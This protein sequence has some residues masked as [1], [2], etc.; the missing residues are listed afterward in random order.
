MA[1]L[2]INS[3]A[4]PRIYTINDRKEFLKQINLLYEYDERAGI[5]EYDGGYCRE[6]AETLALMN[7]LTEHGYELECGFK[8]ITAARN[9]TKLKKHNLSYVEYK[10]NQIELFS[11]RP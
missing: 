7:V 4:Y 3:I 5:Y 1:Y 2:T 8:N 9:L 11:N 6:A 10:E